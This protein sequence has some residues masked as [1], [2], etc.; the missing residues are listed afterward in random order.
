MDEAVNQNSEFGSTEADALGTILAWSPDSPDW[1]RDALRRLCTSERLN[2]NDLAELLAI[3]KGEDRGS[4]LTADHIRDPAAT[5]VK[6]TLDTLKNLKHV[7]A[8][9]P[10]QRLAFK[11]SGLTVIYGDNGAG[12]SGYA[13]VLKQACRARLP[14]GDVIHPNV[15]AN[16]TG[17]PQADISFWV[18]G[19]RRSRTWQQGSPAD[20]ALTA[21]GVFDS[22]TAN[23]HVDAT[24]ELAY[25]PTPL[26]IMAALAE[27]CRSLKSRL[28]TEIE[29][30]EKR[31]PAVLKSARHKSKK[32]DVGKL[33]DSLSA[34][35]RL[36]AETAAQQVEDLAGLSE[37]QDAR[38]KLLDADLTGDPARAAGQLQMLKSQVET[39]TRRLSG[40]AKAITVEQIETLR[41][42]RQDFDTARTAAGLASADLFSGEP[43][44]DVGSDVWRSLWEAARK[45]SDGSAYPG[46]PFPV[47]GDDVRCVLCQQELTP[48]AS[49]RLDRFEAFVLDESKKREDSARQAY[50][51]A[52]SLVAD[53]CLSLHELGALL[54]AIRDDLDDARLADTV[55]RVG[56]MAVWRR[57]A[58]L[59]SLETDGNPELPPFAP[60]PVAELDAHVSDLA[61]R[62]TALRAEQAAPERKALIDE[63]AELAARRL[64]AGIRE[65]VLA[66]IG[67][68]T[69][70]DRLKEARKATATNRITSLSTHLAETLVTDRLRARFAQEV[71][72]LGAAGHAIELQQ[73]PSAAGIPFFHVRLE[74]KPDE[75]VG[76]VLSEGEHRCVAL[77]AFLAE[78][79]T[80]DTASAIVFDDPVSSLDHTRRTRVAERLAAEGLK[81]Q[82]VIF[83]HDIAFL[84]LLK[85]AWKKETGRANIPLEYRVV[86]RGGNAAGFCSSEDLPDKVKSVED[87]LPSKRR[88][89]AR[90]KFHHTCG[91][92]ADWRR[93]VGSFAK[94]LREAWE[95]A[96]EEVVSPVV[97][98]LSQKVKTGGLIKLTVL[99]EQHCTIMHEAYD[100]L[101]KLIH[102]E[103]K[104]INPQL[105]TPDDIEREI[106][107]LEDWIKGIQKRQGRVKKGPSHHP[108]S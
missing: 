58:L 65:D 9:Q 35:A 32:T 4:P 72:K 80:V 70:I 21:I 25:M 36:S 33:L 49:A 98:R 20:A 16:E 50:R 60:V 87:V 84:V 86:S 55:R 28:T 38:L 44:P 2:E 10:G 83:T 64:L 90:V 75:P 40:I 24:N 8:L 106:D 67:R 17:T 102:S 56:L 19:Q 45:Y 71:E 3:C 14:R 77:A 95:R 103:A 91:N 18:G 22:R 5:G 6:V 73:A 97:V 62:A 61:E 48:E 1:Q 30:L 93:E 100:R 12:K 81:R 85:D 76:E 88:H 92:Q 89:L 59:R 63:R 78:L 7:N 13:R 107:A 74:D 26:K 52:R 51:E 57:R 96:V 99:Q 31:T 23:V 37:D 41:A 105:P 46:R 42:R 43:L 108:S 53:Q 104:E 34:L 29:T 79:A 66:E 69:E 47:T 82:V 15:Y 27:A 11:R 94:E 54:A 101:S 68:L 39:G